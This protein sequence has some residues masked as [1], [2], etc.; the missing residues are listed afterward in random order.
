MGDPNEHPILGDID[1]G[2]LEAVKA[3]VLADLAVLEQRGLGAMRWTPLMKAIFYRR[4]DIALWLIEHRGQ[5]DLEARDRMGDAA[6]HMAIRSSRLDVV[7]A[8]VAA[9]A[10]PGA[11]SAHNNTPL[12]VAAEVGRAD[13]LAFLLQLPGVEA[14]IN[15]KN[16]Y[17]LTALTQAAEWGQEACVKLLLDAGTDPN[18]FS[19]FCSPLKGAICRRHAAVVAL[20]LDAGADPTIHPG[21]EV[22]LRAAIRESCL[23]I[24]PIL[25]HAIAEPDRARA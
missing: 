14:Y 2:D 3:H 15:A 13:A 25:R 4:N 24:A 12:W 23:T 10:D 8:L 6:L 22:P 5:H 7:H 20:L 17:A 21:A 19:G 11:L 1:R 9:G 16:G 18:I